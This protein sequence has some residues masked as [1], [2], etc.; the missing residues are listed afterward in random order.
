MHA[1][2]ATEPR[3]FAPA[4]QMFLPTTI[5]QPR[6]KS[7]INPYF[8]RSTRVFGRHSNLPSLSLCL[9]HTLCLRLA[10]I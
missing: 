2:V 6:E 10:C 8:Q 7:I 4:K 3:R 5:L 9:N 1:Y